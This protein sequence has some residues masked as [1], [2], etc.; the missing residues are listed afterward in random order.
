MYRTSRSGISARAA[1]RERVDFI[2]TCSAILTGSRRTFVDVDFALSPGETGQTGAGIG[3]NP[4][5]ACSAVYAGSMFTIVYISLAIDTRVS[6][7]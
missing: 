2:V 6:Q 4:I 5:D 7:L 3:V 1:T